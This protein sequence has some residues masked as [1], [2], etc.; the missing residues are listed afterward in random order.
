MDRRAPEI[1]ACS[2]TQAFWRSNEAASAAPSSYNTTFVFLRPGVKRRRS[3]S[4]DSSTSSS[5]C[6]CSSSN[7]GDIGRLIGQ[8]SVSKAISVNGFFRVVEKDGSFVGLET[9]RALEQKGSKSLR[10]LNGPLWRKMLFMSNKITSII[11]LNVIT[12]IYGKFSMNLITSISR[13]LFSPVLP[14]TSVM[15][16]CINRERDA[17]CE[18]C[19]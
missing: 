9:R 14:L 6:S 8:R 10:K 3:L 5:P 19:V 11:L 16:L 4:L 15:C 12:V 2:K 1:M 13:C 7:G 17:N 18:I